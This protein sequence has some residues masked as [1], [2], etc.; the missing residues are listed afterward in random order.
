MNAL[1]CSRWSTTTRREGA[2]DGLELSG[3]GSVRTEGAS[4]IRE[5]HADC[6]REM[7]L[8]AEVGRRLP[9]E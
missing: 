3:L 6:G 1:F 5:E 8:A 4:D 7:C 9:A 2:E